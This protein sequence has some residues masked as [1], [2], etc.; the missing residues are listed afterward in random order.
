MLS[1]ASPPNVFSIFSL[2]DALPIFRGGARAAVGDVN[3][4]GVG[5]LVVAAGFQGGPRIAGYDGNSLAGGSPARLFADFFALEPSVRNGV[6]S[7]EHTSELQSLA[8]LVCCLMLLLPTCSPFFPY[9]TLFRSSAAG[10]G[11]PSGT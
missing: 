8:Y 6:R 4:D 5:D 11:P 1:N 7:E 3:G 9:T 10:P 2:H